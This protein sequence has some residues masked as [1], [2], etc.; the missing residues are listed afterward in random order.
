MNSTIDEELGILNKYHLNP[1]ELFVIRILLLAAEE[2]DTYLYRYFTIPEE[3]RG[4]FRDILVKLQDKGIIL[5]SYKIPKKG[6]SFNPVEVPFNKNF[7]KGFHKESFEL[8]KELYDAYPMFGNINGATVAL[9]GISKKFDSPEDFYRAYGKAINW[10][11]ETHA[12]IMELL[13]W[14]KNNT[15]FIQFSLASFVID[16]RWNELKA[17]KNGE[18]ANVN[19]NAVKMI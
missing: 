3:D 8:G 18:I 9:R 15:Q 10:N 13:D 16:R 6:E 14:A 12:E 19:F 2:D 5:K 1:N 17:L 11:P 7:I 4:N